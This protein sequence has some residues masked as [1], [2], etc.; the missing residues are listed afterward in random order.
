VLAGALIMESC[1]SPAKHWF[2]PGE[3]FIEWSSLEEIKAHIIA[4]PTRFAENEVIAQR[5]RQKMIDR[6]SAHVFWAEIF[7]EIEL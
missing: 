7:K 6:H 5:M 3:D 2:E 1:D 4:A